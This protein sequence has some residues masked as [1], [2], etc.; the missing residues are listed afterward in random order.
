MTDTTGRA[1]PL[2]KMFSGVPRTYDLINRVFTFCL[3]QSWRRRAAKACLA[4]RPSCVLDLCTGTGDLA[5]MIAELAA[6]G[7][8]V[9]G[10]DFSFP[11]LAKGALKSRGSGRRV[12]FVAGDA[13]RLPFRDRSFDA[14]GV[15]F[16]FRNLTYR[17][18]DRDLFLSE[19]RRVLTPGGRLV[20]VETSRPRTAGV[21]VV[22]HL[23]MRTAVSFLAGVLSGRRAAYKYLAHSAINFF[24][25]EALSEMLIMA[26]FTRV[27]Y[28]TF[29][30]GV[31]ALH[32]AYRK[33]AGS[34]E[35]I[36]NSG[37]S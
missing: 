31:C 32:T 2:Q 33:E 35:G 37:K 20:I 27:G 13:G 29:L 10:V 8:Y 25:P 17:N 5:L 28:R 18:R 4:E 23:Y 34:E 3:D 14:I 1:R 26:G 30:F 36:W 7:A 16:A 12:G 6:P 21:R 9:S 24:A 19:M 11:M 15:A 22:F